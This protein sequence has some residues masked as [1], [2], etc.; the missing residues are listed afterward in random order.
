[1]IL[2]TVKSTIL[3]SVVFSFSSLQIADATTS[4]NSIQPDDPWIT[5]LLAAQYDCSEQF[6]LT[7]FS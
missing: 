5:Q 1:M 6:K 7:Q 2:L 3:L 4:E